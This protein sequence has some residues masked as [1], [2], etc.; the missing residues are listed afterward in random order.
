MGP[1]AKPGQL[2]HICKSFVHLNYEKGK[3]LIIAVNIFLFYTFF[4]YGWLAALVFFVVISP[5]NL[6]W[7]SYDD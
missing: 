1:V 6:R 2:S 5:Q 7:L 4:R 3:N